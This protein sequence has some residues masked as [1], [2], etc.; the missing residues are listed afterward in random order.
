MAITLAG[1]GISEAQVRQNLA[2]A[3][4]APSAP[5]TTA[6]KAPAPTAPSPTGGAVMA[7]GTVSMTGNVAT[8]Q[9]R[10]ADF[11]VPQSSVARSTALAS[12]RT[13]QDLL[14]RRAELE[15]AAISANAPSQAETDLT[16]QLNQTRQLS[17]KAQLALS[18]ETER[19][20]TTP[21]LT[22]VISQNFASDTARRYAR[23]LS[24]LG[25]AQSGLADALSAEVS[26]RTS[27]VSAAE[28]LLKADR[29]T[30]SLI[31]DLQKMTNPTLIGSPQVN[32]VTGDVTVFRQDPQT[33]AITSESV[34][35]VGPSKSFISTN[36]STET[37]AQGNKVNVL[38]GVNADGTV[39][40]IKLGVSGTAGAAGS[41]E[42]LYSGLTPA[43]ATA[44]RSQVSAFK[45]EPTITNFSTI[46]EGRN[47]ANSLDTKTKNPAD[48]QALIYSL[49]KA[50]DPGSVV[51][52][53]EY[54]TAQKYAQSWIKSYGKGVEQALLGTG[55]LSETARDNIKKTIEQR[56]QSSKK[57][58]E[59]L[60]SQY[61]SGINSLTGRS[62]GSSFIRD[63]R[64]PEDEVAKVTET[65]F[66]TKSGKTFKIKSEAVAPAA[67]VA[68]TA[69]STPQATRQAP[70]PTNP[71]AGLGQG[72]GGFN[73]TGLFR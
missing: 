24:D 15:Q 2:S 47:F 63:Y 59:N 58:Y 8:A 46:Q 18:R 56:Y 35:N 62:D 7:D 27:A 12:G 71:L 34:G 14:N 9:P 48:D 42:Q 23:T 44:V 66:T 17:R 41:D 61:E 20:Q 28:G 40:T 21:G 60:Y 10:G 13:V 49:A 65:E 51:R 36:F 25:V 3:G 1:N 32:Q 73:L 50:L 69:T 68:P 70:Q 30:V 55:F 11:A 43:T 57:S 31:Q 39:S 16:E 54:A 4:F 33:G 72:Y 29:D 26:K 22:Q 37:D 6:P 45:S 67:P 38:Y 53:G 19:L 5:E 52:E 64:I